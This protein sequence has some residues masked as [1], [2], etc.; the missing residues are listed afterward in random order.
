MTRN[1]AGRRR[2]PDEPPLIPWWARVSVYVVA[3]VAAFGGAV[4]GQLTGEQA[5]A[6]A[7]ALISALGPALAIGT[8]T[9]DDE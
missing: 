2:L 5:T 8:A 4:V 7:L 9:K 6:A 3:I 1:Y